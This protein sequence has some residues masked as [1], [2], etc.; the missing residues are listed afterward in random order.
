MKEIEDNISIFVQNHFP[1]FYN[2]QGNNFI[3]FVKEYY[4]WTQQTNNNIY[5]ARNLL[6]YR[7]IDK[8]IDEFLYH[9][10]EKYLP[11]APV[12]YNKTRS[13]VKNSLD[14]Y[15]SKGTERGV[16]LIFQEVWGLSDINLYY[17]GS[18]VIKPSDGEWFVPSYLEISLSPKTPTFQGKQITGST[19][20]ATAFVEGISRKSLAGRYIDILYLSNIRGNFLY[21]EVITV[22]GDLQECPVVV[23]SAT[24]ITI[25]DGGREF[26]AGDVVDIV[27]QRRGKQGKA[28]INSSVNSTGKVSFTLLD[29][30]TGYRLV[31]V[32]KIAEVMLSI[33]NKSS[34]NVY[35]NDFSIDE[36]VYQP[37]AN[38]AF[39]SSN[40]SFQ[41]GDF[42]TG[43]NAT[44]SLSTGRIV[45]KFQNNIT[46]TVTSNSTSNTVVGVGTSFVSQIANN[47]YVKFQACT[48]T[49]QVYSVTSNTQLTLT[50]VG[51]DVTANGMTQANGS[52][53]VI[54]LS[55]DWSL[56]DRISGS[57][58]LI[59]SYTDRTATGRVIGVNAE[60]IGL[61]E[62]SNSF[63][64]NNY[65]FFYGATSNVYA[66]VSVV[67]SGSGATFT[68]GGLT[69]E[70]SVFLNTDLIGGNN[71]ITTL[72]LSGT[73]TSNT[74][75][76]Q[77]NGVG[78]SFTT[79]LYSG[80]Y[81][82]FGGNTAVYQVN[83]VS[84]NTILTLT[85][86]SRLAT[87]NTISVTN[88]QYKTIPLNALQY[89]FPKMPTANINI[90]LNN[91][92]TTDSYNIGTISSLAGINP[93]SGYNISPFVLVRD[94]GI[95]QFNR[96]DLHIAISNKSGNFTVGEELV[97]NFSK[98]S[99][100]LSI[101]G[102]NTS[103]TTNENITQVINSTANGYGQ[104]TSSNTSV[105]FVVVS[106]TSNSTY[107]NSFVNSA[108][109]AAAT[110]TVTSNAT[111]PQVNGT[112][113]TFTSSFTAGDFIKFSGN[114]LVFQINTISN[115]TTLNLKTNSAV[116]TSTNTISKATNVAIGMTSGR[117]FFIDTSLANAQIS[118]SRGNVI[119]SSS[120]FINATRKTFNQSFT[121]G[122]PITGSISGATA[123]VGSVSQIAGSSLMGNNAVVNS[124][125]GIVN[126]SISDL[127]IIDSGFAY[128]QGEPITLSKEDSPYIASGYINLIN[129]GVG[130]GYFKSTKGFLNSD[131]Y[132]HD[133]DFYQTYSY[134][135]QAAVPLDVYGET[136]KKLMH[137][138]G[139]KLFGNVVKTSNVNLAITTSGVQIII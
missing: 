34:A 27:S 91:V 70:E 102:S 93:G 18:D 85:A 31:T 60:A 122:I 53:L 16:K 76:P 17:P 97:Q 69:D 83:V 137:V 30:G 96:R 116:I 38:I 5:F 136:L 74:T 98:P 101:S 19:S 44:T 26:S 126:G 4:N 52:F 48:S 135:V 86:N 54:K 75:S 132:I 1:D 22:D 120:S 9:F 39:Y 73:V 118:I 62:V 13:N 3:E 77:V 87:S 92:L 42:V 89:G 2:E 80:A 100:T 138:A 57:A 104:V 24:T 20:N 6:E 79:D 36:Y 139:T 29:G 128:E 58:A 63:S 115:N 50:T 103:Y 71:G 133:G 84:N 114:N 33:T 78:T 7:D 49:F 130:E 8:T 88:G 28:R 82:K 15:R 64:S 124:F 90:I 25:N 131:K 41:I 110:G 11:G 119:N 106:G 107:G 14:I 35:I 99:Y 61:T 56:T 37:L 68:V 59:S 112:G 66:N 23:G 109:S 51:P 32:P 46:G 47:D 127:S 129:Q 10:K 111:S 94:D 105:A 121:A 55:G 40:T 21:D 117:I 72:L 123:D 43:A 125:A 134:Q 113:T 45:G 65:N 108:L 67:G 95:S 81:I 12:F